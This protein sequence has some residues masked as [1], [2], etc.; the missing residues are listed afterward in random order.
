VTFTFKRLH[1]PTG[2]V[3]TGTYEGERWA[4]LYAKFAQWNA[5]APGVWQY[6]LA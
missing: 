5:R 2:Q 1:I 4:D 6:W 3:T